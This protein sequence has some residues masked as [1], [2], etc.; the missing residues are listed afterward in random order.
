LKIAAGVFPAASF[1]KQAS[2]LFYKAH[3][4]EESAGELPAERG[5]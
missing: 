4:S 2:M 5:L 3:F 1:A